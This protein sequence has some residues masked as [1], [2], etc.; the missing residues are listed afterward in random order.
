MKN[1]SHFIF[2]HLISIGL[3]QNTATYSNM[4]ALLITSLIVLYIIDS[5]TR[6]V[7]I[8]V[9]IKL[10]SKS[11]TN[12]DDLLV[13][14][15]TPRNF[16][17]IIPVIIADRLLRVVFVDFPTI[18]NFI[19]KALEVFVVVLTLWI[20]RSTLNTFKDFFK[21]LPRLKDKPI[22][23]FI[24]VFM[25]FA[26][27]VGFM[28][29][30]AIISGTSVWKFMTALGAASAVVLL[31][32]KDTILG[33]VASIQ[34]SIN[35]MVR[36][37]D[38]ITFQK[39]GADGNVTEINLATVKVQNFDKTITTIPTYA[40]I[41]DSFK[42]WRGME[43]SGGRRIKRAVIIK[44][45]SV[46]FLTPTD[47]ENF[48]KIQLI[49]DYLQHRQ[50]DIDNYNQEH[51]IDKTLA[52]NGRNL[53]NLGVFRKYMETYAKNH[54]AINED[55]MIMARQLAPTSQGIPIEIYA[56]S[57]DKRWKNYEYI[58]ADVF[59]HLLASLPYFD[60][61]LFELPSN[62]SFKNYHHE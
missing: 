45:E 21:T 4:I 57:A 18:A 37:G 13:K 40:L 47:L 49:T 14:N 53:T 15:K 52:I 20:V 51:H 28:Y 61:E 2:D 11:K 12:F 58:I 31:I 17:H 1:I 5:I 48:K 26:W 7:I 23:S 39:F 25:I 59:D 22:D 56:F 32:F 38:W 44:Q 3:P 10:S 42:N 41:S 8:Y 24:Q 9:S 60:L 36:I 62:T 55:M 16:A 50:E 19:D 6:R 29:A 54:S 43:E 33:F 30:F 34:V 35:D 27:I 46:K